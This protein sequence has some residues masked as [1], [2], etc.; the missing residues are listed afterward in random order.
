MFRRNKQQP[1]DPGNTQPKSQE[2][3]D[4]RLYDQ[5]PGIDYTGY[6]KVYRKWFD[7]EQK[8]RSENH[9]LIYTSGEGR[10]EGGQYVRTCDSYESQFKELAKKNPAILEFIECH[11][12]YGNFKTLKILTFEEY[13]LKVTGIK[14]TNTLKVKTNVIRLPSNP[15]ARNI[16]GL[17]IPGAPGVFGE[18]FGELARLAPNNIL[19]H[20]RVYFPDNSFKDL[21]VRIVYKQGN[22]DFIGT[23]ELGEA[24]RGSVGV[25][26]D[27]DIGDQSSIYDPSQMFEG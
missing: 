24:I 20:M 1:D 8:V 11:D 17:I 25:S 5:I 6:M 21:Y 27:W 16:N 22:P 14:D 19:A 12:N 13:F 2:S 7:E 9:I 10:Y 15:G 4:Q 26:L 23:Y 3:L 18:R